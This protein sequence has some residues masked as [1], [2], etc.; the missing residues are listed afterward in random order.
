MLEMKLQSL[1]G[2]ILLISYSLTYS[3]N[4]TITDLTNTDTDT[5]KFRLEEGDWIN[6]LMDDMSLEEK[7][8]QL[9]MVAAFP[10]H[11][12][13][14]LNDLQKLIHQYHI[15]GVLIMQGNRT[16]QRKLVEKLQ[17]ISLTPLLIAQDAEW[18]LSMRLEDAPGFPKAMTLGAIRDDSLLFQMGV[19][20]GQQLREVGVNVNF[21]P[22]LD[23]NNNPSNPVINYRSFGDNKYN[24][25]RKGILFS[26]GLQSQGVLACV[27]HFPGHGDTETD[28]HLD[29]PTISHSKSRLDTLELYPFTKSIE[30]GIGA[31]MVGHLHIPALDS[32]PNLPATLSPRIVNGVI[33]DSLGYNGLIFTDA[34]NMRAVT[35]YFEPG[36][37]DLKAIQAGN[38][39]LVYPQNISQAFFQIKQALSDGSLS[40]EVF[41]SK[42]QRI[43]KYKYKLGLDTLELK[44]KAEWGE[45]DIEAQV[46]KKKLYEAAITLARNKNELLPLQH[47]SYRKI[48]YVQV[49]GNSNNGLDLNLRKYAAIET[50]YMRKTFTEGERKQLIEKLRTQGFNTII[51][52]IYDANYNLEKK[53]GIREETI[54]LCEE[55]GN[56]DAESIGC[57]FGNPYT[58]K[59]IPLQTAMLVAYE[60]D[61]E[62]ERVIAAAI[63]GGIPIRGKLPISASDTFPEGTGILINTPTRFGFAYPEEEGLD[64]QSLMKIDSI[65]SHYIDRGAMPGCAI[66]VLKGNNVVYEKGFGNTKTGR[67]SRKV[68]PY[69]HTYD[70]ASVTKIAAT[71]LSIMQLVEQG[72]LKLD[73]PIETYLPEFRNTNKANLTIRRLLQHNAGLP[74]WRPFFLNTFLDESHKQID[75]RFGSYQR[76]DLHTVQIAPNLYITPAFQDTIWQ[77]IIDMDVRNT[78][79]V[80]YSDIG[81]IILGRIIESAS[82]IG[83]ENYMQKLFYTPL[84]MDKT[85]FNPAQKGKSKDCPP[86][87]V[88]HFWRRSEIQGYVHDE[89]AAIFGGKAGH[90]GLFSNIYDLAKLMLMLKN[91]GTY[92]NDQFLSDST[93]KLFTRRQM[94][95]NRKGLGWDK[96]EVREGRSNP[97]S[98]HCSAETYGHTGFTGISAWVDPTYDIVYIFLS[99]R[100]YPKASNRLMQRENI[101]VVIMDQIYEAMFNYQRQ[102]LEG[103]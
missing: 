54:A 25:A 21:A 4:T 35:K 64:S 45:L 95:N 92:G 91:G 40:L 10:H 60:S 34:L 63:F 100:T 79:R 72:W 42:V 1:I 66:M 13:S 82:G 59:F 99:N 101:R 9:F 2:Y 8:G 6:T 86:T 87:Q 68:D 93:I 51:I 48:A 43:L 22:V 81:M 94:S 61:P 65:A 97:V 12:E 19:L 96:P 76:T 67:H 18:G 75:P 15:G 28:S 41:D 62:L 23:I 3:Q 57:V 27:K 78:R 5:L 17:R 56:M 36:K 14:H 74:P 88:D 103:S 69:I 80:R 85:M 52:G 20:M 33:R 90:A 29:L 73:A 26:Q 39:I 30:S 70:L 49:G 102:R 84:G 7:I 24:V 31:I 50:F 11:G 44:D 47:L 16:Q 53:Y 32:T 38:D 89:T 98:K 71:T 37:L 55:I 77:E 83:M 46:L 58:L